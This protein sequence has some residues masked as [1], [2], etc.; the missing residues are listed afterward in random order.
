MA[1][2]TKALLKED[3]NG[4]ELVQV[5]FESCDSF[6]C[7][8]LRIWVGCRNVRSGFGAVE[9]HVHFLQFPGFLCL[10][11]EPIIVLFEHVFHP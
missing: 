10:F 5:R 3:G 1:L 8:F 4:K 2:K 6:D 11:F 9:G 7:F